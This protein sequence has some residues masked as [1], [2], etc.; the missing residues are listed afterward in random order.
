[1]SACFIKVNFTPLSHCSVCVAVTFSSDG[2]VETIRT[3]IYIYLVRFIA[4]HAN[5]VFN[6]N[7]TWGFRDEAGLMLTLSDQCGVFLWNCYTL[8]TQVFW[9]CSHVSQNGM[10]RYRAHSKTCDQVLLSVW[11]LL[12]CLCRAPSLTRG[13]ACRFLSK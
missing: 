4:D 9:N 3:Q 2:R 13:R 12:S 11:K 6:R 5:T 1:M 7:P 8:C 10:L